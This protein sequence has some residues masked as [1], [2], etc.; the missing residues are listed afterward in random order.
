MKNRAPALLAVIGA[1][2]IYGLNYVIAKGIMPDYMNP[3][4]IIFVRTSIATVVFW[5]IASWLKKEKIEREDWKTL[6]LSGFFGISLNQL[7][8]FEGLNLTTSI[9]ASILMVGIPI[10]VLFFSKIFQNI[11]FGRSKFIGMM[12]GSVGAIYLILGKGKIDF[13]SSTSLGNVLIM[14]NVTSYAFFLV[15]IKPLASKYHPITLMKWVFL[16]G[17]LFVAPFTLPKFI[18]TDWSIIPIHIWLSIGYVVVF[19]TILAYFLNNYSLTRMSAATNSAFIYSQPAIAT[20]VAVIFGKE[21]LHFQQIIAALF[22][23]VGVYFVIKKS[24][25]VYET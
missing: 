9:N 19:A 1:N 4:A 10:A 15:L 13:S 12:L 5:F 6:L 21:Q 2:I 7:M 24:K 8:F 14:I 11:S 20:L 23:F 25:K 17:F 16:F 22:I 3:R 18:Q